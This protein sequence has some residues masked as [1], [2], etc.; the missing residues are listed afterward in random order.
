MRLI[1]HDGV[2]VIRREAVKAANKALHAGTDYP[3]IRWGVLC[4]LLNAGGTA[5]KAQRLM[6]QL[7]TVR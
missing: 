5:K 7:F 3:C 4:A 1:Y 6:Y 2:K